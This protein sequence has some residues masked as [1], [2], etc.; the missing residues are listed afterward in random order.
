[1]VQSPIDILRLAYERAS[2]HLDEPLVHDAD[3][4][5]RI[6]AICRNLRNRACARFLLATTLMKIYKPAIDIRKP[7]TEIGDVDAYSG[8]TFDEAYVTAFVVQHSLP[9]NSTTAFLTPAF[10]NRNVTL[11]PDMVMMGRPEALYRATLQ[12]LTDIQSGFVTAETVL[13]ETV[14]LLLVVRNEQKSQVESLLAGLRHS[15]DI[16]ALSSEAIVNVI[17]QHLEVAHSSRLPVLVVAAVYQAAEKH[18]GERLLPLMG[19][20][21]ADEQTGSLGDLE[22]TLVD[23]DRVVTFM[24]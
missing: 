12:L 16:M 9:C 3:I 8:R 4:Q 23:D 17:Q 10:R 6:E 5:S 15:G 14:R 1:M 22:I 13:F 11:T 24:R 18:L 7:Y 21:A 19:H 20:N 2:A